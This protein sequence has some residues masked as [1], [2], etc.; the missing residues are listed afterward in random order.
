MNIQQKFV[1]ANWMFTQR[2]RIWPVSVEILKYNTTKQY[3]IVIYHRVTYIGHLSRFVFNKKGDCM[4]YRF[5]LFVQSCSL[6]KAGMN[7]AH[8]LHDKNLCYYKF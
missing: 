8:H 2:L 7:N 4:N 3:D 6:W 5:K 1:L